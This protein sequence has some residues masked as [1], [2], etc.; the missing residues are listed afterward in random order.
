MMTKPEKD[1]SGRK[2]LISKLLH[3]V[4]VFFI[5][6]TLSVLVYTVPN[7]RQTYQSSS[8]SIFGITTL[9]FNIIIPVVIGLIAAFG[10]Y[11]GLSDLRRKVGDHSGSEIAK[12]SYT[13]DDRSRAIAR[14]LPKAAVTLDVNGKVTFLNPAASDLFNTHKTGDHEAI[15]RFIDTFNLRSSLEEVFKGGTVTVEKTGT[16]PDS[17]ETDKTWRITGVPITRQEEV[18]EALLLIED[19][20]QFRMLEDELIRS[21]DRYRNIF[22]H[23]PCGIFF[24]DS[25]GHYLDANPAALEMLGYSL[26]ELT[27]LS[28]RELSADSDRRLRRLRETPGWIEEDTRY[29]RKDGKVVEAQL[30]ASS[31]QS[32]SD[33]YFI[34]ITKD[35]TARNELE[36]SLSAAKARLKAVLSLESRP[37]VLLDTRDRIAN[38]NKAAVDLLDC[39]SE[40]LMGLALEDLVEGDLPPLQET[41]SASSSHCIFNIPDGPPMNLSVIRL[42]LGSSTNS[43]SLLLLSGGPLPVKSESGE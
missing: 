25:Q 20:T 11:F 9:V 10:V 31:Y 6:T 7:L 13:P 41:S 19:R 3:P 21:E 5:V 43:G 40:R 42:P 27:T 2:V 28:T 17:P 14:N 26:E 30:Q 32:G 38:L 15:G 18:V 36:R 12:G 8:T 24:V 33:T 39:P 23:A 16:L 29:L 22:N 34:G 1:I 37:L 35:V 4:P